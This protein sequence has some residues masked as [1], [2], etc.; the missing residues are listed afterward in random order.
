MKKL[1]IV[2]AASAVASLSLGTAAHAQCGEVT[3]G[4]ANWSTAQILAQIDAFILTNGYGCDVT[5]T[6]VST[7]TTLAVAQGSASPLVVSEF[8]ANGVDPIVLQEA[9]DNGE[10][11]L[12][13]VPFPEAGEFWYVSPAF[14]EAYP[15]LDTV[16][17]VLARPD[18]F[19][20]PTVDGAGAFFVC[21]KGFVFGELGFLVCLNQPVSRSGDAGQQCH[22]NCEH[23]RD[24]SAISVGKLLN[25]IPR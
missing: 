4:E 6:P 18:L 15:E 12:T 21:L 13:G 14:A 25:L 8:W 11:S 24:E 10:I 17:K 3:V 20:S 22:T 1:A 19:P 16:E 9:Q 23:R 5:V 7:T 2:A